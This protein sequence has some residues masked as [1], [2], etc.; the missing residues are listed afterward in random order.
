MIR[1]LII[2]CLIGLI[3]ALL[4]AFGIMGLTSSAEFVH[5]ALNQRH[6]ALILLAAG[7]I[8]TMLELRLLLPI[9]RG[10][11]ARTQSRTPDA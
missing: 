9:L 4:L 2:A 8:L 10:M 11:A 6:T 3:G 7:I 1:E 5:P